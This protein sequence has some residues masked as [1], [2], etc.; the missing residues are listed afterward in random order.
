MLKLQTSEMR[1]INGKETPVRVY[2]N[3][4]T[5]SEVVTYQLYTDKQGSRWWTFEDLFSLPFVRQLAAKK[6][7]DLYG[8]DLALADILGHT[9]QLKAIL[10][11]QDAERY[12]KAYAKVLEL[13]TLSTSM[14]DPV[15][16]CIGMSTVY[17][18]LDDE[19]PA[20]Y[21]QGT[22]NQKLTLLSLDLDAQ[23]FFLSWW[24]VHMNRSGQLLK[25]LSQ[26]VSTVNP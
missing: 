22:Q 26:I 25:G 15:K 13:E 7:V 11:S 8:H 1:K 17:L 23:A 12:E 9:A 21:S 19:D 10:K 14:A 24:T 4:V 6:V 18:L 20:T 3:T 2:R 5:G 16:Q